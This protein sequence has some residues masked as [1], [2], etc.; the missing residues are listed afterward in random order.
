M[1]RFLRSINIFT[2]LYYH[3]KN[4]V[5]K[6][7]FFFTIK[8]IYT[9]LTHDLSMD[10]LD[11]S[12]I[13]PNPNI[14]FIILKNNYFK[15]KLK[16]LLIYNPEI[17]FENNFQEVYGEVRYDNYDNLLILRNWDIE[18]DTLLL[19]YQESSGDDK[20]I[21][22]TNLSDF[23]PESKLREIKICYTVFLLCIIHLFI[24]LFI[25]LIENIYDNAH[26]KQTKPIWNEKIT[27]I[28]S[29]NTI[30]ITFI[31]PVILVGK[32]GVSIYREYQGEY[33]LR[34]K[35]TSYAC[36]KPNCEL[37]ENNYTLSILLDSIVKNITFN[38]PGTYY[39]EIDDDF[40]KHETMDQS[41]SD[42]RWPII[43]NPGI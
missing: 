28:D 17:N 9:I 3:L 23:M 15:D 4:V 30:N 6:F 24:H 22:S 16:K 29:V 2:F 14:G 42:V 12:F 35:Y 33:V 40:I 39:I 31:H 8:L 18:N 21:L 37:S 5:N 19:V 10:D 41:I 11:V 20:H 43:Y 25:F 36:I 27:N 1:T 13:Q 26:I 32:V 38:L 34:Q 7:Y